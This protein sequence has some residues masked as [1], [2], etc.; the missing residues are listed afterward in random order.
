[1]ANQ[2][3]PRTAVGKFNSS[4]NALKKGIYTNAVMPG[5]DPQAL[6]ELAEN[7]SET[8]EICDAAGE[9][10]IRRFLQHTLQANRLQTAQIDL[11]Q[12]KMH[13]HSTRLNFCREVNFSPLAAEEIPG[14]Y[15]DDDP[16]PK[17]NAE[18]IYEVFQEAS[19]LKKHYTADLMLAAKSRLPNLWR[20]L[21]GE[22]G[23]ATQKV[24]AT[25]G[26]RL[27]ANYKQQNPQANIQCYLDDLKEE[28]K[29][30]L[31]WGENESRYVAVIAGLR[32]KAT[33]DV[34]SD[35]N[36]SRAEAALH[37]RSQELLASMV[38]LKRE[39]ASTEIVKP[40]PAIATQPADASDTLK[41]KSKR[42]QNTA[43]A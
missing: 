25:I 24:Y 28:K 8:F 12:A 32:A 42:S 31:L 34:I 41:A 33:L 17:E 1:M 23:S 13:S 9:I 4:R 26:E 19:Q 15:F 5:E 3:G 20:G 35:P 43:K 37:R 22:P 30:Q 27:S 2:T 10:T 38:A 11:I 7:L 36:L 21:M 39:N 29:Y 40:L 16:G 6:E 14:W 18:F